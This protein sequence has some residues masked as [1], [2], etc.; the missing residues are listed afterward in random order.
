MDLHHCRFPVGFLFVL[1]F[2]LADFCVCR[3]KQPQA[4]LQKMIDYMCG[5]GANCNSIHE[6]WPC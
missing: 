5:A 6:Q 3:S 1:A 2:E 4:A